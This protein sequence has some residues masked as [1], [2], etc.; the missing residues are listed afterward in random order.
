MSEPASELPA[1]NL[2]SVVDNARRGVVTHITLQGERVAAIVPEYLLQVLDHLVILLAATSDVLALRELPE[3]LLQA[4]PW[5]HA[6]PGHELKAM[7]REL[8]QAAAPQTPEAA[9]E[10]RSVLAGWQ[11]TA[12]AYAG[13]AV[14]EALRSPLGDY[15]PVPEPYAA[16]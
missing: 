13:P 4:F 8:R 9:D 1:D 7:A 16:R 12:E 10:A 2:V 14:L 3:V 5:A 11:A 6:L 15:G